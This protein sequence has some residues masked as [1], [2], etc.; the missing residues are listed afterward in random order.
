MTDDDID[1]RRLMAFDSIAAQELSGIDAG[2]LNRHEELAS[3]VD[4]SLESPRIVDV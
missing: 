2:R 4:K 3:Q 1:D